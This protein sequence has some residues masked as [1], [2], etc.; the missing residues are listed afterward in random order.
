[1]IVTR[2]VAGKADPAMREIADRD[3]DHE[4]DRD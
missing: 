2:A 1:M 3:A 4:C